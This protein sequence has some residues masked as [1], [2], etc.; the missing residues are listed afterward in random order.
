MNP[1][2]C[3]YI[4]G[5]HCTEPNISLNLKLS[6]KLYL[7]YLKL[8]INRFNPFRGEALSK[9]DLKATITIYLVKPL[10]R[11]II[12]KTQ[13]SAYF[14]DFFTST[15]LNFSGCSA[16]AKA[17]TSSIHCTGWMFRSRFTLSGISSKSRS[18]SLG[19]ITVLIP[20]R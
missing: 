1:L 18:L 8:S 10:N 2:N 16:N 17:K 4:C 14:L 13:H 5:L 11:K 15:G 12:K 3:Y 6:S 20:P 9:S 7:Y 19:I